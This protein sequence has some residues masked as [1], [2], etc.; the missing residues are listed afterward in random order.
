M[1][2]KQTG[3]QHEQHNYQAS[4]SQ[5]QHQMWKQ[6]QQQQQY[7]SQLPPF[8]PLRPP[9][10]SDG[11][12]L[13]YGL[14]PPNVVQHQNQMHHFRHPPPGP[15]VFQNFGQNTMSASNPFPHGV[16]APPSWSSQPLGIPQP[17][18]M[19][20]N[21]TQ[22]QTHGGNHGRLSVGQTSNFKSSRLDVSNHQLKSDGSLPRQTFNPSHSPMQDAS[23]QPQLRHH[24]APYPPLSIAGER[25]HNEADA[26]NF[27]QAF[28]QHIPPPYPP[29]SRKDAMS[30]EFPISQELTEKEKDQ[31]WIDNFLSKIHTRQ[32]KNRN[33]SINIEIK[34]PHVKDMIRSYGRLLED[35]KLQRDLLLENLDIDSESW[36]LALQQVSD[37]KRDLLS[38]SGKLDDP[39]FIEK[40]TEKLKK[41][42]KKS[43]NLKRRRELEYEDRQEYLEKIQVVDE[44]INANIAKAEKDRQ[45]KLKEKELQKEIDTTLFE[46]RKKKKEADKTL[47]ILRGLRKLRHLRNASSK[48]KGVVLP[49]SSETVFEK[50]I[51]QMEQFMNRQRAVYTAEEQAMQVMLEEE[52]EE[53]KEQERLIFQ[54]KLE[55]KERKKLNLRKKLLFGDEKVHDPNLI[56]FQQFYE[57]AEVNMDA[58]LHVRYEWDQCLVLPQ[59]GGASSIPVA[60][61]T[62]EPPSSHIWE[63]AL[64]D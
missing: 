20:N 54:Q 35:L 43:L 5:Q 52:R 7:S 44:K 12:S 50:R 37:I 25:S 2:Y 39:K 60:W 13:N 56:P 41:R 14:P 31:Q 63:T 40:V 48:Q 58:L 9:A 33:K 55:E 21:K 27:S 16:A 32:R 1:E 3:S 24:G 6:S 8:P 61:V 49:A 47:E 29:P 51:S 19:P 22:L 28:P 30:G 23:Y 17:F 36:H 57:Q 53:T 4:P 26:Q 64:A 45:E 59:T 62:P 10:P 34:I 42:R 15:K 38:V 46:V 11:P 18:D